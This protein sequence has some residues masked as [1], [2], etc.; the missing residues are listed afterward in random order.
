MN[1]NCVNARLVADLAVAQK[2]LCRLI[3]PLDEHNYRAQFNPDLSPLGWHLGHTIFTENFWLHKVILGNAEYTKDKGKLYIPGNNEKSTRGKALPPKLKLLQET[4]AQQENN[5]H[6]LSRPPAKLAKHPL[7][8]NNYLLCFLLQHHALHTETMY[9]ILT[10]KHLNN[11]Q[12]HYES[13]QKLKATPIQTDP[14]IFETNTYPIGSDQIECFD[15]EKPKRHHHI[16]TFVLNKYAVSNG[17]YLSFINDGGYQKKQYWCTQGWQWRQQYQINAPNTWRQHQHE[18]FNISEYGAQ[19]LATN[20]PVYGT[21]LYEAKAF[22][23]WAKAR[24]PHE[25]EFEVAHRLESKI[26]PSQRWEWCNNIFHAYNGYQPFPY[27]EYSQP[28]FDNRH[29]TL[30]GGSPYIHPI[31]QR[32]SFRNFYTPDRRHTYTGIRLAFEI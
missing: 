24:L 7:M 23:H 18:W 6:L 10:A 29:Y 15:N 31:M 27:K 9:A 8:K 3:E 14:L 1:D 26:A 32:A 2:K 19:D 12:I 20:E 25:Y 22:A 28:W 17:E 13:K 4:T 21:S 30:K 11:E 5:I 16:T